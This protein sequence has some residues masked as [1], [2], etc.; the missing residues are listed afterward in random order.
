MKTAISITLLLIIS[1]FGSSI[2]QVTVNNDGSPPDPSAMLDIQATDKGLLLPRLDYND[3][4]DPAAPGLMIFFT[5]NGP[6]GDN[7]IYLYNGTAWVMLN[8]E[9]TLVGSTAEGGIVFWEDQIQGFGLVSMPMDQGFS[10]WGCYGTLI[11]ADAQHTEIGTGDANSSAI[12]AGCAEADI[13]A[14]ICGDLDFNGYTDWFLPSLDELREMQLQKQAI[15]SFSDWLYWSSTE[16]G[17]AEFPEEAAWVVSFTDGLYGW[18]SKEYPVTF[19]C[20]RKYYLNVE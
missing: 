6:E 10:G 19:R 1:I 7:L 8:S 17:Q 16:A 4:P 18:T 9:A 12:I 2:A 14:K 13:P 5:A 20:I 3:R 15:G 11:G